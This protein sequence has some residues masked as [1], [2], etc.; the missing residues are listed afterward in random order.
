[1]WSRGPIS[2]TRGEVL[3]IGVD[4]VARTRPTG[5]CAPAARINPPAIRTTPSAAPIH[6]GLRRRR[7]RRSGTLCCS[8]YGG[9]GGAASVVEIGTRGADERR[10]HRGRR[11]GGSGGS[12]QFSPTLGQI[13]CRPSRPDPTRRPRK[14]KTVSPSIRL[15]TKSPA[16]SVTAEVGPVAVAEP[17]EVRPDSWSLVRARQT[18]GSALVAT[19]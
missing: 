19:R 2:V 18:S 11:I 17:R 9:S 10:N 7:G 14:A 16:S 6:R 5:T 13:L 8:G 15:V 1:V 4:K 12:G 3:T